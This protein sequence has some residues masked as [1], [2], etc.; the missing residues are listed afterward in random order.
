MKIIETSALFIMDWC[1]MCKS[2]EERGA[3]L[4]FNCVVAQELWSLV[5]LF[6]GCFLGNAFL[7]VGFVILLEGHFGKRSNG[8]IWNVAPLCLIWCL[9]RERNARHFEEEEIHK[10]K[11]KFLLLETLYDLTLAS[12]TFSTMDFLSSWIL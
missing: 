4:F 5:K 1:F 7:C 9:W 10:T 6:V 11:L 3:H 8:E 12:H 2:H